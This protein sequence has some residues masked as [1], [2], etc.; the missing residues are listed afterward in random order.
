MI[1]VDVTPS[2]S[3]CVKEESTW[4]AAA[5]ACGYDFAEHDTAGRVLLG[6]AASALGL[7]QAAVYKYAGTNCGGGATDSGDIERDEWVQLGSKYYTNAN[8][9]NG[10]D[11]DSEC[12]YVFTVSIKLKSDNSMWYKVRS[13]NLDPWNWNDVTTE[14][15]QI[16][17]YGDCVNICEDLPGYFPDDPSE[18]CF[19]GGL[20]RQ[21]LQND[22]LTGC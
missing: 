5:A 16:G 11:G 9:E 14:D 13:Q 3:A 1:L 22:I 21:R 6:T 19:I 15:V 10:Y 8:A 12:N 18:D 17:T 2:S 20:T 7:E 4:T